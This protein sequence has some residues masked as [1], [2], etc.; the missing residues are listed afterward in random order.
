MCSDKGTF[1]DVFFLTVSLGGVNFGGGGTD[2][3]GTGVARMT[4]SSR[5]VAVAVVVVVVV[6]TAGGASSC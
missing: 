4:G 3:V 2:A 1:R 6:V 5:L